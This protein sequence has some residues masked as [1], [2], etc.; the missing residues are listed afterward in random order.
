MGKNITETDAIALGEP[1]GVRRE[2]QLAAKHLGGLL[3]VV[4]VGLALDT[5]H[6]IEVVHAHRPQ[7]HGRCIRHPR[8][9]A[10][11]FIQRAASSA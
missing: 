1:A 10:P 7:C 4:A 6:R 11:D 2:A 5:E 8:D 9:H 3:V